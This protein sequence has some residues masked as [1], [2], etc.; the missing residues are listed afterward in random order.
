MA[1]EIRN[2]SKIFVDR[3]TGEPFRAVDDVSF[4]IADRSFVTLL[5]PSGCGK[6]TI[7]RMIAGFEAPNAG[8]IL[9]HGK[10][11]TRVAA[12]KRGLPVVFQHYA[13]FPHMNVFENVAYPLRIRKWKHAAILK[14]VEETLEMMNLKRL[15][16]RRPEEL[17]G[18][19]QQRVALAR[20][21]SGGE[22][23]VLFDEPLSNLD[24]KLR[25]QM[26]L[27]LKRLQQQAG[28]T[29]L[30]VT[31]DQEEAMALSDVVIVMNSG[32]IEQMGSPEDI[33]FRPRNR[34]IADFIGKANFVPAEA[35]RSMR[36]YLIKLWQKEVGLVDG[37]EGIA[38]PCEVMIR[39]EAFR[40]GAGSKEF[41]AKLSVANFLGNTTVMELEMGDKRIL[42]E[43]PSETTDEECRVGQTLH[44][45]LDP[46]RMFVLPPH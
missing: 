46:R 6:T 8:A 3:V 23:I 35:T 43:R 2:L 38:G 39:P 41:E 24:A 7:L 13:L 31:H 21:L 17:S 30:Y 4:S 26:R 40:F 44:F 16:Q 34:F 10:E 15:A 14:R 32:R 37:V 19:Q 18:G 28:L 20:A 45:S 33:Y 36:G 11:I 22:K 29:A 27:E 5:G 9:V 42:S 12:E 1:I 25:I